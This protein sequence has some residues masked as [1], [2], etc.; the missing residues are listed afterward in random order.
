MSKSN[1]KIYLKKVQILRENKILLLKNEF[2]F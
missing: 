2:D 1:P